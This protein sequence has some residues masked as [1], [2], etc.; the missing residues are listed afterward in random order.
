MVTSDQCRAQASTT[1]TAYSSQC[2]KYSSGR[3]MQC[4]FSLGQG[5]LMVFKMFPTSSSFSFVSCSTLGGGPG[6]PDIVG[7]GGNCL[8]S[9]SLYR[10]KT[11][12]LSDPGIPRYNLSL[13]ISNGISFSL[14]IPSSLAF[15]VPVSTASHSDRSINIPS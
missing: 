9:A 12:L 14:Q 5:Q 15:S 8:I 7:G 6:I 3:V 1:T 2:F 13:V 10:S 11:A 4:S